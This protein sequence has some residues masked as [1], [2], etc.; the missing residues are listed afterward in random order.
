MPNRP[1]VSRKTVQRLNRFRFVAKYRLLRGAGT[2]LRGNP[3]TF[4]EFL[5]GDELHTFSYPIRNEAELAEA[6]ARPLGIDAA[7]VL[8]LFDEGR[9]TVRE[10]WVDRPRG[11]VADLT[12][13]RLGWYAVVRTFK[14]RL[15]VESGADRG[16][17]SIVILAALEANRREGRDGRL[18]SIDP[19][20]GAGF[21]VPPNARTSWTMLRCSSTTA[22]SEGLAGE[23]VDMYVHDSLKVLG[24]EELRAVLPLAADRFAFV[25]AWDTPEMR[26]ELAGAGAT[27][28]PFSEEA[29]HPVFP[30]SDVMFAFLERTSAPRAAEP[31]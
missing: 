12:G 29:A 26:A 21:L 25:S 3:R 27:I 20:L 5:C 2:T 11:T 18:V 1:V 10:L 6:L 30:G 16:R 4:L 17:G 31:S 9:R 23:T 15:V 24:L 14:P 19:Q 13:R 28:Y 8:A 7:A 22:L